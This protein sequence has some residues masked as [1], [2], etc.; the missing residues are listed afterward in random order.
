MGPN[1]LLS[2]KLLSFSQTGPYGAQFP[3][4]TLSTTVKRLNAE[5]FY[6]F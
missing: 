5:T 2:K 4:G 6:L 1:Q 3:R